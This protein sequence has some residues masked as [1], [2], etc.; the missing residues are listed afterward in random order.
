[1]TTDPDRYLAELDEDRAERRSWRRSDTD[2]PR[3]APRPQRPPRATWRTD[4]GPQR[5][6]AEE[7]ERGLA[8][9][10]AIREQM[11]AR[12]ADPS[13]SGR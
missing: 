11:A 8:A 10:A 3:T 6:T 5:P 13:W 1:M 7:R 9:I 2:A 12:R 4:P